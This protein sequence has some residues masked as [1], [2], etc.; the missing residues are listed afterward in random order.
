MSQATLTLS[1]Q[2]RT[3]YRGQHNAVNAALASLFSGATAPAA[4]VAF[5]LWQDTATGTLKQRDAANSA[6]LPAA[7]TQA[8]QTAVADALY[9]QK[10]LPLSGAIASVAS[11]ATVAL[12]FAASNRFSLTLGQSLT[13]AA[14]LNI[15]AVGQSVM[16]ILRQDA[17]GAR[18]VAW[19]SPW[20]F[21]GATAP[22]LS[23]TAGA[24][25]VV[26]GEVVSATEIL[27]NTLYKFG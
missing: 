21:P 6:W 14:P 23:T 1:N 24:I 18:A 12:D 15:P 8:D 3:A 20:K 27:C 17:T 4:P 19:A 2:S 26:V 7:L 16:I 13:I 22:T 9:F 25:D 5:Q 11:A 10:A